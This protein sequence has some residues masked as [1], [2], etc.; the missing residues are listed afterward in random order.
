MKCAS[1]LTSRPRLWAPHALF[2]VH[3]VPKCAGTGQIQ[4]WQ[5]TEE[6]CLGDLSLGIAKSYVDRRKN[7]QREAVLVRPERA[8]WFLYPPFIRIL[9]LKL[10]SLPWCFTQRVTWKPCV[11]NPVDSAVGENAGLWLQLSKWAVLTRLAPGRHLKCAANEIEKTIFLSLF[12]VQIQSPPPTL[13]SSKQIKGG[14]NLDTVLQD[15][16][17]TAHS[18]VH[19][20]AEFH[21]PSHWYF[22]Y[23]C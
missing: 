13:P 10:P 2:S 23:C 22:P 18:T 19:L 6:W 15:C 16:A 8:D 5:G 1:E 4:L 21:Q 3:T 9:S 14:I 17:H 11:F 12:A 7:V 20:P